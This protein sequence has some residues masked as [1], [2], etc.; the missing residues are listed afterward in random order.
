MPAG[1]PTDYK[2]EYCDKVIE[3]GRSGASKAEMAH[4]IG[5]SRNTLD[6][7]ADANPEFL[8]AVKESQ[9]FS[10]GWWESEGRKATFG[11]TPGFNATSFIFNMKNRFAADWKDKQEVEHS[12]EVKHSAADMT[13]DELARIATAS[14]K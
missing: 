6:N 14:G 4:A 3:L 5:I 8:R 11:G 1:R 12:G 9:S 13:D 7:W 2:P 10:Q